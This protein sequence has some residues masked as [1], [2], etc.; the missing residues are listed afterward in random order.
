VIRKWEHILPEFE[1]RAFVFNR[2]L[3]ALTQYYKTTYVPQMSEQREKLEQ[4]IKAFFSETEQLIPARVLDYV[5]D[6]AV[7]PASGKIWIVEMYVS[8]LTIAFFLICRNT[9]PPVAGQALFDW[10]LEADKNILLGNS[11]FEFRIIVDR[12][13]DPMKDIRSFLE[14]EM[15]KK[16]KSEKK[17]VQRKYS[18]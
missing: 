15:A 3:T 13:A 9:P 18:V 8:R 11:P 17:P 4:M 5:V 14:D 10:D 12:P 2:K 1:F 7:E 6:Y 16:K